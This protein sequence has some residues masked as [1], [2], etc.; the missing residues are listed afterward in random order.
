MGQLNT[1]LTWT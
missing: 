1:W